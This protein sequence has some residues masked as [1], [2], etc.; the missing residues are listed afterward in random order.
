MNVSH[1]A[2]SPD[3]QLYYDDGHQRI[4][5]CDNDRGKGTYIRDDG[6]VQSCTLGKLG[7]VR[8]SKSNFVRILRSGEP[9]LEGHTEVG[10]GSQSYVVWMKMRER[11][12][13]MTRELGRGD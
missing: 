6:W 12:C 2:Y 1:I 8:R 7:S 13:W 3:Q 9:S 4:C 11:G 10:Y 5:S